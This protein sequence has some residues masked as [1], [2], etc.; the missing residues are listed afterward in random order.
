L[1]ADT[2]ITFPNPI[3]ASLG[4]SANLLIGGLSSSAIYYIRAKQ[5]CVAGFQP[6]SSYSN[7]VS[8]S[9]LQSTTTTTTSTTTTTTTAA[10]T[11]TTTTLAK[12]NFSASVAYNISSSTVAC[13]DRDICI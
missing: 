3:T 5:N 10:P 1:E 9:T 12:Q 11:T 4:C 13:N 2:I 7:V 8:G 6:T